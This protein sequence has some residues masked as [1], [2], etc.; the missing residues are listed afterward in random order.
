MKIK[1][2]ALSMILIGSSFVSG[3]IFSANCNGYN[4]HYISAQNQQ[5]VGFLGGHLYVPTTITRGSYVGTKT[6]HPPHSN[7]VTF[8]LYNFTAKLPKV[9]DADWAKAKAGQQVILPNGLPLSCT[10]HFVAIGGEI[11]GNLLGEPNRTLWCAA[12]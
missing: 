7:P 4:G 1:N 2:C 9:S 10:C 5:D 12:P 11:P 8:K 6:L 3:A